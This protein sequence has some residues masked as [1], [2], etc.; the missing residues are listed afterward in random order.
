[1]GEQLQMGQVDEIGI[2]SAVP[3]EEIGDW[4]AW[5]RLG[6]ADQGCQRDCT[7]GFRGMGP[8]GV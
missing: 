4:G 2:Q 5:S 1:M 3:G 8:F 6:N 7:F